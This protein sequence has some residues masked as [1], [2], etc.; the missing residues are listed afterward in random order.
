MKKWSV[1]TAGAPHVL[2]KNKARSQEVPPGLSRSPSCPTL[3]SARC[4]RL[5]LSSVIW[6]GETCDVGDGAGQQ[7]RGSAIPGF[8][9]CNSEPGLPVSLAHPKTGK[10]FAS[11]F[12]R[13]ASAHGTGPAA[14]HMLSCT[15]PHPAEDRMA[16]T[17][18]EC[19]FRK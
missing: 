16:G 12:S 14:A 5:L 13:G 4:F 1:W 3:P 9:V 15:R 11:L 8:K 7:K 2:E 17:R 18:Q 6:E 10:G 19:V